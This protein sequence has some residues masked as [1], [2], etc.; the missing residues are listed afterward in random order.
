MTIVFQ[1]CNILTVDYELYINQKYICKIHSSK[2]SFKKVDVDVTKGS[3]VVSI[4]PN[5]KKEKINILYNLINSFFELVTLYLFLIITVGTIKGNVYEFCEYPHLYYG[6]NLKLDV[7]NN[8]MIVFDFKSSTINSNNKIKIISPK[9]K[10][11]SKI[12]ILLND[13]INNFDKKYI[14]RKFIKIFNIYNMLF[15]PFFIMLSLGII[16]SLIESNVPLLVFLLVLF[17]PLIFYYIFEVIKCLRVYKAY[18]AQVTRG[19][20]NTGDG[21]MS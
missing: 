9:V 7:D 6:K 12:K 8:S 4:F 2:D 16:N 1:N 11:C 20:G 5:Y 13:E 18:M 19:R 3:I 14:K 17:I 21:S 10:E 15:Y